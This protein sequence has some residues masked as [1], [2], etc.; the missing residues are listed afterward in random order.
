MSRVTNLLTRM[1]YIEFMHA[2]YV[3][4]QIEGCSDSVENDECRSSLYSEW[5]ACS[6]DN[7][8]ATPSSTFFLE[9]ITLFAILSTK[10]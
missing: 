7:P 4:I 3:R 2:L 5:V 9:S 8:F 1:T 10:S 6:F